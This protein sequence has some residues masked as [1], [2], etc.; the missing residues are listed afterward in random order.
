MARPSKFTKVLAMKICKRLAEGESLRGVC[1]DDKMPNRSTIHDWLLQ[2]ATEEAKPEIKEFSNQYEKS[3]NIRAENMF[4][5]IEA[6]ADDG[7]NDYMEKERQDGS[8]YEV[9]NSE[10]VQRSRL[11]ID[12]RKW[13][14]SK[15]LPKKFGDRSIVATEDEDG[16]TQPI[17]GI[18]INPPENAGETT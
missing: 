3:I 16:N 11:R 7:E 1:R 4:D 17:T 12:A 2:G 15:V 18:V 9:L 5:E 10:H 6:I 13:Y 8:T 14:L